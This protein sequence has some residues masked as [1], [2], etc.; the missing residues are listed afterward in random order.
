MGSYRYRILIEGLYTL[1]EPSRGKKKREALKTLNF[2][3]VASFNLRV[4]GPDLGPTRWTL[5]S[6]TEAAA[7]SLT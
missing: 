3:P 6:S 5:K 4:S 7:R 1:G 2:P